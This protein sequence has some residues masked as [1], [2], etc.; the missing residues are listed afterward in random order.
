MQDIFSGRIEQRLFLKESELFSSEGHLQLLTEKYGKKIDSELNLYLKE[1]DFKANLFF[2]KTE[3]NILGK[4]ANVYTPLLTFNATLLFDEYYFAKIDA[5]SLEINPIFIEILSNENDYDRSKLAKEIAHIVSHEGKV[6]IGNILNLEKYLNTNFPQIHIEQLRDYPELKSQQLLKSDSHQ[7]FSI[8]NAACLCISKKSKN[9]QSVL[10]ELQRLEQDEALS[11]PLISYLLK[12]FEAPT[13]QGNSN[14]FIHHVPAILSKPQEDILQIVSEAKFSVIVGPPGTGKSFTI[15]SLAIN[16]AKKGK[17]ILIVSSNEQAVSV[18]EE[19][20]KNE[21]DLPEFATRISNK[22]SLKSGLNKNLKRWLSGVGLRGKI[23]NDIAFYNQEISALSREQKKLLIEI[24]DLE[25]KELILG[26][27]LKDANIG[28]IDKIKRYFL[29]RSIEKIEEYYKILD[30][31]ISFNQ[32]VIFANKNLI[33][34]KHKERIKDNIYT[35]RETLSK[36][37]QGLNSKS[38]GEQLSHFQ[39]IDFKVLTSVFPV[40]LSTINEVGIGLPMEK[41]MFDLVFFDEASQTD[42]A[43][44]LPVLQRAKSV[45]VC[46]DPEQLS[47]VSFLAKDKQKNLAETLKD[48]SLDKTFNYRSNSFLNQVLDALKSQTQINFLNEHYRSLPDLISYSNSEFYGNS[49]RIM[50]DIPRNKTKKGLEKVFVNGTRTKTGINIEEGAFILRTIREIIEKT[51]DTELTTPTSI[52]ILS[53]F[54]SQ[55]DYLIQEIKEN[56]SLEEIKQHNIQLGTAHSFQGDERD[57]MFISAVVDDNAHH[58]AFNHINKSDVFNVSITRARNKMYFTHSIKNINSLKREQH[59]YKFLTHQFQF[60]QNNETHYADENIDQISEWLIKQSE[61]NIDDTQINYT[62]AS[63]GIDIL[64]RKGGKYYGIDLVGFSGA[65]AQQVSIDKI[66]VLT[67]LNIPIFPLAI[68]D[69][70]YNKENLKI[71]LTSYFRR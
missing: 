43:S 68:S 3:Q 2:L 18:I 62:V 12:N 14:N 28:F 5:S 71:A 65:F 31:Y 6:D 70:T 52:G 67:Q 23:E 53:P 34:L 41:E 58:G 11:K 59:L 10:D 22:R 47:G 39:A 37:R 63:V 20:F 36:F 29:G 57:V 45:V 16:E 32:R 64:V 26:E 19:K 49:L 61:F 21:F 1:K 38:S 24:K 9:T 30:R 66:R 13:Q 8:I 54:R 56:F 15:A 46:G 42:I 40:W 35:N 51:K 44:V 69:W 48:S 7:N 50:T 25:E 4:T 27:Y 33:S 17:S 60:N 55:V